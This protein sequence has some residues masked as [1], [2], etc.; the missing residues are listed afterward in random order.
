MRE[1]PRWA[2]S[3]AGISPP[4]GLLPR[5]RPDRRQVHPRVPDQDLLDPHVDALGRL[6]FDIDAGARK[7]LVG[8]PPHDGRPDR[9][10]RPQ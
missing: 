8:Q 4:F 6:A 1:A 5:R 9:G 3:L 7:L 2:S 10:V